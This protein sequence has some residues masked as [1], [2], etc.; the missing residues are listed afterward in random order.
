MTDTKELKSTVKRIPP[1]AGIGR[2]KGVPNKNTSLLKDAI[3][4]A[5]TKAGDKEG[6]VGY[7]IKQARET[8]TAFLPLLAKVLPLQV[9]GEDGGAIKTITTIQL[10]ALKPG[11]S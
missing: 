2:K 5:A 6:L 7:L 10:V 4:E 1:N 11:D 3:I 9:T 8:P